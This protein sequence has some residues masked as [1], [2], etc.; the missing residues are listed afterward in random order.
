MASLKNLLPEP[1]LSDILTERFQVTFFTLYISL[2]WLDSM[3]I[4][5]Y[6]KYSI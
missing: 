1:L 2:C 6:D 4:Y 3:V 5:Y